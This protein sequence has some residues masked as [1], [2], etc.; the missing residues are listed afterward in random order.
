MPIISDV[1]DQ[2]YC[3]N[4]CWISSRQ[5]KS[6]GRWPAWRVWGHI[7]GI[8][9]LLSTMIESQSAELFSQLSIFVFTVIGIIFIHGII[10][11]PSLLYFFTKIT[12]LQLWKNGKPAFISAFATS[13]SAAS[14]TS[15]R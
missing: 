4:Q 15:P 8:F 10:V 13:S 14:V 5:T 6:D 9:A 2:I 3:S 11:I 7:V 1:E 12:P